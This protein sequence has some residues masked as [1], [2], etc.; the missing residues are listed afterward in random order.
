MPSSA[1][2]VSCDAERAPLAPG[3]HCF[4][5]VEEAENAWRLLE[6]VSVGCLY[7]TFDW[8]SSF[9]ANIGEKK[10]VTPLFVVIADAGGPV[11]GFALGLEGHYGMRIARPLGYGFGN[12]NTGLWRPDAMDTRTGSL[13][14]GAMKEEAAK[15]GADCLDL[16]DMAHSIDGRPNPISAKAQP[17]SFTPIFAMALEADF[18][19]LY[20]KH[21]SSSARKKLNAKERKLGEM[22]G[23]RI[24]LARDED[25]A[26]RFLDCMIAQRS[27]RAASSG[28]PNAFA[29]YAARDFLRSLLLA[30][31]ADGSKRFTIHALEAEGKVRAT[32]LGGMRGNCFYAYAN[33]IAEDDFLKFSPGDVLLK[34]LVREMCEAGLERFDFGLGAERYKTAWAQAESLSDI[35]IPL[36]IRGRLYSASTRAKTALKRVIRDNPRAWSLVRRARALR[37]Q[38]S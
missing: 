16:R 11:A 1:V 31:I 34:A 9:Q 5:T 12:Q 17:Q 33:S 27:A 28:I 22:N 29:G 25:T 10:C 3:V 7:N 8:L 15:L 20:R 35:V 36:S 4:R 30:S 18:E 2:S 19:A 38:M 13:L 24:S 32:Y 26:L 6:S 14:L 23:F 37:A 21:R